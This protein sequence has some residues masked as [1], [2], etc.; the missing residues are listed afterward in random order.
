MIKS[1]E[2]VKQGNV[3]KDFI[4]FPF[5]LKGS[6][7]VSFC[8]NDFAGRKIMRRPQSFLLNFFHF[9]LFIWSVYSVNMVAFNAANQ[10][11]MMFLIIAVSAQN[12]MQCHSKNDQNILN[13]S[14]GSK[15]CH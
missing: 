14:I 13:I 12:F 3:E 5:H 4:S 10:E 1:L 6:V 8:L 9:I 7:G 15:I 2:I 11:Y